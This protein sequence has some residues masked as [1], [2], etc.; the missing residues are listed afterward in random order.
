MDA[1]AVQT[2]P[3]VSTI[4]AHRRLVRS[5]AACRFLSDWTWYSGG[6][7]CDTAHEDITGICTSATAPLT[8]TQR[9]STVTSAQDAP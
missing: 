6:P 5:I 9:G 4:V 3:T 2:S 1:P 7:H 8:G